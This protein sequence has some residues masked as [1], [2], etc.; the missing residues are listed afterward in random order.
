MA[1]K[2]KRYEELKALKGK[3]RSEGFTYRKLSEETGISVDAINNKLNGYSVMD[4]DDVELM[5]KA[6]NIPANEILLYFF[7]RTLRNAANEAV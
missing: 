4:A 1:K 7:P 3:M 5:V 6:L 2:V